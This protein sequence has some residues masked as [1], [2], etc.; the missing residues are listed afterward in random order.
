MDQVGAKS[1]LQING[2]I[3]QRDGLLALYL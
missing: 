1:A 3:D 2:V